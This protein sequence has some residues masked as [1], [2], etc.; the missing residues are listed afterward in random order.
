MLS[1]IFLLR[2]RTEMTDAG[3]PTPALVLQMPMP[4]YCMCMTLLYINNLNGHSSGRG[5]KKL[6]QLLRIFSSL[7]SLQS[8][9]VLFALIKRMQFFL[10][11]AFYPQN[12]P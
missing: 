2:Y 11:P 3:M 12:E 4:T 10:V 5:E 8:R 7:I 1:S 6:R 9:H